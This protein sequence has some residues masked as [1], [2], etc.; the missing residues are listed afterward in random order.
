MS[1]QPLF[2]TFTGMRSSIAAG[3]GQSGGA[4]NAVQFCLAII[5]ILREA[6][7]KMPE[8]VGFRT[9]YRSEPGMIGNYPWTYADESR[10][11][12]IQR[13]EY[14]REDLYTEEQMKQYGR[15]LLEEAA[16]LFPQPHMEYF[17]QEI[18]DEIRKLKETL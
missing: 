6:S 7:M 10:R 17:G 5:C 2:A 1:E 12:K 16:A 13:P 14:E 18:Q 3:S 15:S 9:R 4:A 8:P 11:S